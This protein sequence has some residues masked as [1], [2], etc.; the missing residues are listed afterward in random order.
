MNSQID[1]QLKRVVTRIIHYNLAGVDHSIIPDARQTVEFVQQTMTGANQLHRVFPTG[2]WV[3]KGTQLTCGLWDSVRVEQIDGYDSYINGQQASQVPTRRV[4]TDT[5]DSNIVVTYR[6]PVDG[7]RI[8]FWQDIVYRTPSGQVVKTVPRAISGTLVNGSATVGMR[9]VNIYLNNHLPHGYQYVSGKLNSDEVVR[10]PTPAALVITIKRANLDQQR[11]QRPQ[12]KALITFVEK[13]NQGHVLGTTSVTGHFASS[14]DASKVVEADKPAGWLVDSAVSNL[15]VEI[16][17]SL[18]VPL[19]QGI[20]ISTTDDVPSDG[21]RPQALTSE[22]PSRSITRHPKDSQH[23][24]FASLK[25]ML[26]L[27][28]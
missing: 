24:G 17:G 26:G 22:S 1:T 19:T 23:L 21:L 20:D 18:T 12:G 4:D 9:E 2:K 28:E 25:S 27:D 7:G 11:S 14:V 5:M 10:D 6:R 8:T 13:D 16:P 3:V 15:E